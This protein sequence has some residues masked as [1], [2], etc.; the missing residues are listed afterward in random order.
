MATGASTV[1][2]TNHSSFSPIEIESVKSTATAITQIRKRREAT[3]SARID[4]ARRRGDE[5]QWSAS[6]YGSSWPPNS[7]LMATSADGPTSP[8]ATTWPP[9]PMTA[10]LRSVAH[11]CSKSASA[12]AVPVGISAAIRRMSASV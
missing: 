12:T 1:S 7:S 6:E 11:R 9:A 5:R 10:S 8:S 2:A 4:L 3:A